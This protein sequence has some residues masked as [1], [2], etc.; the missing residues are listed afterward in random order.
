MEKKGI[1]ATLPKIWSKI[2]LKTLR[3]EFRISWNFFG[4]TLS[5]I[6]V[7]GGRDQIGNETRDKTLSE[8]L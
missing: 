8:Y 5:E 6:D 2:V 1:Q 7:F 4:K 3:A